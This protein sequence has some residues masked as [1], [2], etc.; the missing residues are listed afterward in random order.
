VIRIEE[1]ISVTVSDLQQQE[2]TAKHAWQS[3]ESVI[4][5]LRLSCKEYASSRFGF[6]RLFST[7]ALANRAEFRETV[8]SNYLDK[9]G[10]QN[11]GRDKKGE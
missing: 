4:Q 3:M 5:Q 2:P 6:D 1:N 7:L 10:R 9:S 11:N 8:L